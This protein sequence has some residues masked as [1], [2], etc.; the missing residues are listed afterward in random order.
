L[1]IAMI[2]NH[3]EAIK[4]TGESFKIHTIK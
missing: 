4:N 3:M 1:P 2:P